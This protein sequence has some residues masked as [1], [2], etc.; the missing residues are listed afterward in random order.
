VSWP[1]CIGVVLLVFTAFLLTGSPWCLL[2]LGLLY[3]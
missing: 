1:A 2:L 3:L